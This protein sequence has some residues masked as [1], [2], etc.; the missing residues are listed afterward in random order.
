[1]PGGKPVIDVPELTPR[2]PERVDGPV[3][4]T[5]EPPSTAKCSAVPRGTMPAS[6]PVAAQAMMPARTKALRFVRVIP[7]KRLQPMIAVKMAVSRKWPGESPGEADLQPAQ[8]DRATGAS[9][10]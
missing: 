1:M 3:L 8:Q 10:F 5:V 6:A 9:G 7:A 2:S 4:V